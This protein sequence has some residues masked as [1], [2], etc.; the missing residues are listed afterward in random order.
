M[1]LDLNTH[2]LLL[3]YSKYNIYIMYTTAID[4]DLQTTNYIYQYDVT[5]LA[6]T[7]YLEREHLICEFKCSLCVSQHLIFH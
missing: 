7:I 3:I 1:T 5:A 4:I 2:K 6:M